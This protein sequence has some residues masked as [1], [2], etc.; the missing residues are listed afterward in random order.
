MQKSGI[1][2]D[3]YTIGSNSPP[4]I[5]AE[6][7]ANHNGSLERAIETL[8]A[9]KR[10][11]VNAVKLQT[12]TADTI[13]ID[14]DKPDFVIKDGLWD[15]YKLYD[16]YKQAETPFEWHEPLFAHARNIGI[17]IFS[18]PFDETAVDLLEKLNTPAYK[19]A[20][21]ELID[22]PLIRYVAST[23]K[24][25]IMSTGMA[26]E[27][28]IEEAVTAAREAGC[29]DL[30]LLHCISSYPTPM[31]QANLRQI[32]EL[33]RRFN[34][35][36]GLSDHTM[37]TAASVAAVAMGACLIEKHF[38][39]SRDDKGLDSEFSSEPRDLERL[40][41]DAKDAWLAL[42]VGGYTRQKAE[43]ASKPFRRSL[44]FVKDLPA[45]HVIGPED[46]RR[47]RPGMGLPPRF[48]S[49]I[50]G[51]CLKVPVKFGDPTSFD[52]FF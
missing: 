15:G 6:V 26:S 5:V 24:P 16:L 29:K 10:C 13:T 42:G 41:A 20:S 48:Y 38:T 17:T 37:G 18:T 14:C 46:I 49:D 27:Q 11:G 35:F 30:L 3:G 7:S 43:E 36:T 4:Y 32:P 2:I 22:L 33:A 23:G 34:V 52:L 21:F 28:E 44:Y 45:G 40:C 39:L 19:I 31:D 51:R 25:M 9:A 50:I 1:V 12:F 8:S 47:I